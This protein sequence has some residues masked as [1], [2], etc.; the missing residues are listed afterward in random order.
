V[1]YWGARPTERR[2]L[3]KQLLRTGNLLDRRPERQ[4]SSDPT[5]N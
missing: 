4:A 2:R 1:N 3:V 5:T